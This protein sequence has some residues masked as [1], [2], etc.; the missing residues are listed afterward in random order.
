MALPTVGT[1]YQPLGDS[2][3]GSLPSFWT[4][5]GGPGTIVYPQPYDSAKGQIEPP[6][7]S[8]GMYVWG[9]GHIT[10]LPWIFK[11]Y[12]DVNN[13]EAALVCCPVCSF[14]QYIIEPYSEYLNYIQN[15]IV[16]A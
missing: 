9:C 5:P 11:A 10:N 3:V 16:I 15:P 6:L 7:I 1:L 4:Q 13:E 12:D 14:I 8:V 2:P